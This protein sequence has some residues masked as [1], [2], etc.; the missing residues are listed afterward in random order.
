MQPDVKNLRLFF[1][2]IQYETRLRSVA[3]VC[4]DLIKVYS[5][6]NNITF[7]RSYYTE[8]LYD[9]FNES[10]CQL[11]NY[12]F[13]TLFNISYDIADKNYKSQLLYTKEQSDFVKSGTTVS[14]E[15]WINYLELKKNK[16]KS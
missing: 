6:L 14:V 9:N 4:Y 7:Y 16:N 3:S 8:S 10:Y 12:T 1:T 11:N 5:F 15:E 13:I 2:K